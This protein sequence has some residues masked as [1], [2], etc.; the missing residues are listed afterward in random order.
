M[1]YLR[2][3]GPE[4]TPEA[5]LLWLGMAARRSWR[6]ISKQNKQLNLGNVGFS[7]AYL[8]QVNHIYF[9]FLKENFSFFLKPN[10]VEHLHV[11]DLFKYKS[12]AFI[13][14]LQYVEHLVYQHGVWLTLH[15]LMTQTLPV[16]LI[17]TL[18]VTTK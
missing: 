8:R 6:N 18:I 9:Q 2:G 10:C 3:T 4:I 7:L 16:Q 1:V 14:C 17:S 11:W 5:H 13:D 12:S 15:Q